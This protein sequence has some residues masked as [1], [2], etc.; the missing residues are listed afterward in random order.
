MVLRRPYAFL[1]KH[2][3]LIHII[4]FLLLAYL[5]FQ[6]NNILKFFKDYIANSINME[7]IAS[8]YINSFI[9][10]SVVIIILLSITIYYLMKYKNKPKRLYAIT[11]ISSIVGIIFFIYLT[12]SI[13]TLE[14]SIF[15]ARQIRLL[16][17]IS[18]INFWLF[19]VTSIPILVRGLGFDI[20]KFDFNK[21]LEEL[22]LE[23]KDSEEVEVNV[24]LSGAKIERKGRQIRRELNYYYKE[25]KFFINIILGV[26]LLI[27]IIMFPFNKLVI[28]GTIGENQL[29]S[30]NYYNLKVTDSYI[31]EKKRTSINNSYVIVKID[32]KGKYNKY[33]LNLD[34]LVLEGKN[35][36]YIP[37][38]KYYNYYSDLGLGYRR[39]Y[40][41]TDEYKSYI[42][43]YNID[44]IDR[45]SKLIIHYLAEDKKIK[46]SPEKIN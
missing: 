18:R 32:I 27:L 34:N 21:D 8:N 33:S 1:I 38:L 5:A 25:N 46:L 11:I 24:D 43:I 7:I 31:S 37:S 39:E 10:I 36:K 23:E 22:K 2:F 17:D 41:D 28:H 14:T 42:L 35:N 45:D 12:S 13:K 16:R 29:M 19:L 3:R 4:L 20:K 44:N 40:L 30:T 15:S 9:F 26:V 6:A